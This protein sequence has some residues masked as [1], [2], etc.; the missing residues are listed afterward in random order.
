MA[1]VMK[2]QVD[3][4]K[5]RASV[6]RLKEASAIHVSLDEFGPIA[7]FSPAESHGA[8]AVHATAYVHDDSDALTQS[9]GCSCTHGFGI[10]RLQRF[11]QPC[12]HSF[13]LR[14]A[15]RLRVR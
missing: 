4:S 10:F 7:S 9:G 15:Q 2:T 8:V 3:M 14:S 12:L 1:C 11:P 6:R 13:V 5:R